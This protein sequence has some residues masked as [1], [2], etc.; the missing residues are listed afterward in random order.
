MTAALVCVPPDQIGAIW[1]HAAPFIERP[2]AKRGDDTPESIRADIEAGHALL[3]IVWDGSALIAAAVT[4]IMSTVRRRVLRIVCCA[5]NDVH[6]WIHLIKELEA[7][8]KREGCDVCR[9]EGR[10][11]WKTMLSEYRQPYIVLEK[12]L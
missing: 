3:W 1:P 7:Y 10:E 9:V 8:G 12:A 4:R 5:G 11:G 6:R 2:F